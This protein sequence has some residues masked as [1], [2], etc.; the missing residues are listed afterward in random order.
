MDSM[1]FW[2]WA[3]RIASAAAL[4]LAGVAIGVCISLWWLGD[5][6]LEAVDA[7]SDLFQTCADMRNET[8]PDPC[9]LGW[10]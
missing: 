4:V 5:F 10:S 2:D 6:S 1:V 3:G 9:N 7:L 8:T